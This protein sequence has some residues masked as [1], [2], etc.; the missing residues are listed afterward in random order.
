MDANHGGTARS[1]RPHPVGVN[2][3]AAGSLPRSCLPPRSC[4]A[5]TGGRRRSVPITYSSS[6]MAQEGLAQSLPTGM[7]EWSFCSPRRTNTH[8][9]SGPR[10]GTR[11]IP[12]R[13]GD[14]GAC[15]D[16]QLVEGIQLRMQLPQSRDVARV[17]QVGHPSAHSIPRALPVTPHGCPRQTSTAD[18]LDHHPTRVIPMRPAVTSAGRPAVRPRAVPSHSRVFSLMVSAVT[19]RPRRGCG[20]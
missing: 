12:Q 9:F 5:A 17:T 18:L 14:D 15:V 8:E 11:K 13:L 16:S 1:A 6:V 10:S 3:T 20:T 19:R 7:N 4:V 2:G